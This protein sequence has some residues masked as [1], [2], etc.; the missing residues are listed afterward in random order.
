MIC[1]R[2]KETETTSDLPAFCGQCVDE[3]QQ[4]AHQRG[5]EIARIV[6]DPLPLKDGEIPDVKGTTTWKRK[7]KR[8]QA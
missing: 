4:W 6:A 3:M 2:C 8:G 7:P 1:L 5:F